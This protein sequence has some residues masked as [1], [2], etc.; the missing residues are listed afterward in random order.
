MPPRIS[1]VELGVKMHNESVLGFSTWVI[2]SFGTDPGSVGLLLGS[3]GF[4]EVF[5]DH[6]RFRS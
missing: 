4:S 5:S 6:M 3:Y 1:I 2:N